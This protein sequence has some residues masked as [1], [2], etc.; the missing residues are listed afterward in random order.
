MLPGRGLCVGL[1]TRPEDVYGVSECDREVAVMRRPWPTTSS[2]A[3]GE[4]KCLE[5][6]GQDIH[7]QLRK[8]VFYLCL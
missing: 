6:T 4:R 8:S 2:S 5:G 7:L 1:I 3:M